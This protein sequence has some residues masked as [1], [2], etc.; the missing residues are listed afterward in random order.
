M[1]QFHDVGG[2]ACMRIGDIISHHLAM[3]RG[4]E[5]TETP[6]KRETYGIHGCKAMDELLDIMKD[7]DPVDEPTYYGWITTWSDSFLRSYVKQKLNNVWMYTI[8]LPDPSRQSTSPFHTYCVAV[9]SGQ[10]DHTSVIDW[11]SKE[12][13]SLMNGR[14]YYCSEKRQFLRVK[15]GVVAVLADRPEK[16]FILKTSLL[17]IYGQIA[18]WA[19]D[20]EPN[21]L[22]DCKK[23]FLRRVKAVLQDRHSTSNIVPCKDFPTNEAEVAPLPP[24]PQNDSGISSP[25]NTANPF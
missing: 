23:Y 16:A 15:L 11:Y 3:G 13:E 7:L 5:F 8:T 17:G 10:L 1:S 6:T 25:P 19:A 9:G 21:I 24:I 2:H 20:V 18:S 22:A 4:F 12:V 14:T